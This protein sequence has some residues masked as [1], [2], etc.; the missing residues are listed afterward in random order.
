VYLKKQK[1]LVK[2][3]SDYDQLL[4]ELQKVARW[5]KTLRYFDFKIFSKYGKDDLRELQ[6]DKPIPTDLPPVLIIKLSSAGFSSWKSK[7]EEALSLIGALFKKLDRYT[8]HRNLFSDQLNQDIGHQSSVDIIDQLKAELQAR[9]EAV[10]MNI[11]CEL[12][13]REFISPYLVASIRLA[14]KY[15]QSKHY[16]NSLSLVYEKFVNG[17]HAQGPVDY[18]IM[19]DY[20]DII[21]T[22]VKKESATEGIIQNLLQQQAS[23]EYLSNI[24]INA[25]VVGLERKRKFHEIY[26]ELHMSL[27]TFGVVSNGSEWIFTKCIG[28]KNHFIEKTSIAISNTIK[29]NYSEH[30]VHELEDTIKRILF[31]ITNMIIIQIENVKDNPVIQKIRSIV[32]NPIQLLTNES[33]ECSILLQEI[34]ALN[35]EDEEE[36]NDIED[37]EDC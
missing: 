33:D 9:K 34:T 22:E 37:E 21:L 35:E 15:M 18:I 27:P 12:T 13:C 8:P 14:L 10:N 26:D 4:V 7:E 17:L 1:Q 28:N 16:H 11:P 6:Y 25:D 30:T 24:L 5:R 36:G 32:D 19:L 29:I 31:T 23:L 3:F 20:L 2:H